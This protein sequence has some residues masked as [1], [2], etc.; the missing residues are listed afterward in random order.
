MNQKWAPLSTLVNKKMN[1]VYEAT[2]TRLDSFKQN[3]L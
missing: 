2:F 1:K 3:E